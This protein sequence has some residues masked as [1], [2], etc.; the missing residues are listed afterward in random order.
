MNRFESLLDDHRRFLRTCEEQGWD[1]IPPRLSPVRVQHSCEE[2]DPNTVLERCRVLCSDHGWMQWPDEVRSLPAAPLD[3]MPPLDGE[4]RA[5]DGTRWQLEYRGSNLWRLHRFQVEETESTPTHL[6]EPVTHLND[7]RA[8]APLR[9]LRLY[10]F[11]QQPE[12]ADPSDAAPEPVL[13]V[14]DGFQE[15]RA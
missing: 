10:G 5:A 8:P 14:F 9:Y 1:W 6:A 13:A 11:T 4:G 2:L 15:D 7:H 3:E 12:G